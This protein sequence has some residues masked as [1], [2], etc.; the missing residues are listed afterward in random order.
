MNGDISC[1][2]GANG[3]A[4]RDRYLQ[5]EPAPCLLREQQIHHGASKPYVVLTLRSLLIRGG[6]GRY[7]L[8]ASRPFAPV[9]MRRSLR[10]LPYLRTLVLQ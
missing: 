3:C 1:V 5:Y 2:G 7:V 10:V 6:A 8:R 4:A 9:R